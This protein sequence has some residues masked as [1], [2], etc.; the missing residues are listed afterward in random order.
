MASTQNRISARQGL[1]VALD[2]TFFRNGIAQEPFAIRRVDIYRSSV[3]DENLLTQ[4]L[5]ADPGTPEY[6]APAERRQDPEGNIL[7]GAFRLLFDVPKSYSQDIYFDVW[8]FIADPVGSS[9]DLDDPDL[10]IC[11]SNRFFVFPDGWFLDDGLENIRI[12]FEPLDLKFR[13]PEKRML[14]VGLTPLPLFDFN[15][16]LVMPVLAQLQ[17]FIRVETENCELLV[18]NEPCVI[19]LRMGSFRHSPFVVQFVLDTSRFLIGTYRY[20]I[21]VRLPNGQTRLSEKFTFTVN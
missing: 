12:G 17:T 10:L 6:P 4:I 21:S 20:Q 14:E 9:E 7:P 8:R 13:R 3:K 2:V 11:Q 15:S 19:G 18:D 16:N 1:P 5:F